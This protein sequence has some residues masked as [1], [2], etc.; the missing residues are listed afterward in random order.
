MNK[1]MTAQEFVENSSRCPKC[2]SEN[3]S[4][5]EISVEGDSTYQDGS[6]EDCDARFYTVSRLVGYGLYEHDAADAEVRTV[7]E[8]EQP[9]KE[10][11]YVFTQ[12]LE[13]VEAEYGD[14]PEPEDLPRWKEIIDHANRLLGIEDEEEKGRDDGDTE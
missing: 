3:V 11:L 4:W 12:L 5:D 7:E 9:S 14:D 13:I 2:H 1:P 6:C 8:P 10:W